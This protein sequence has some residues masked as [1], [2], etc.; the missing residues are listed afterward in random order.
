MTTP[1]TA[2]PLS[3]PRG[4]RFRTSRSGLP[5][6]P[7]HPRVA[8]A[9]LWGL[10]YPEFTRAAHARYG[11]TFTVRPG[12]TPPTVVT[13]DRDAIRRLFTGDPLAKRHANDPLRPLVR[14]RSVLLLEPAEH[15][16]RRKLLLPPF[17][18]ERVR[19]YGRVM[20]ELIEKELDDWRPGDVVALFPIAQD[21]T[22]EVILRA[23]LGVSDPDT[24]RRLRE[25]IDDTVG[26]PVSGLRRRL[27]GALGRP[28]R[29]G[30]TGPRRVPELLALAVQLPTPAVLTY[31]PETKVRTR[32]NIATWGFWRTFDRLMEM[33]DA[34]IAGTRADPRLPERDD[35][36]AMLVQARDEDGNG[37]GDD[38]LRDEL[39]TL[40]A[41][42]HET[43]ATAI[44]W[45]GEL[46]A[47]HPAVRARA[48]QAA[49][50]GEDDYLEALVKEVLRLRSPLSVAAGRTLDEPFPIGEHT[51]PPGVPIVV[52]SHA[53]HHDPALY[54]DPE[55]LRPERFLDGSPEPYTWL[56]FGGGAHRCPGAALAE[57]ETKIAL[58]AILRRVDLEPAAPPAAPVRRGVILVPRGGGRVRVAA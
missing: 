48:T 40:I 27:P 37:L 30:R 31:F 56:P 28:P 20:E 44:A 34:Q 45:G 18:G 2:P 6:G 23:V 25:L 10:R 57:L 36:L 12:T 1:A 19:A 32:W 14:D 58:S 53:L 29:R 3:R 13:A 39:I 9:V 49:H 51:V 33:L 41:A 8:Q 15:L 38:D 55:E 16:Q 5:P 17:H 24:R 26:Y 43:T 35:V 21:L 46:L 47:H 22:L 54:P 7:R 52:D 50:A 11:P 4:L 42:G